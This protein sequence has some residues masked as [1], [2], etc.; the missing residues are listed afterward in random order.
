MLVATFEIRGARMPEREREIR[1][2]S[3]LKVTPTTLVTLDVIYERA[4]FS[5]VSAIRG[6]DYLSCR[7]AQ[8][9]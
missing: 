6:A 1:G 4:E 7:G 5:F 2:A 3:F 8:L 9:R